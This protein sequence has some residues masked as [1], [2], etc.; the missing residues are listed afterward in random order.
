VSFSSEIEASARAGEPA[1]SAAVFYVRS[2]GISIPRNSA[3]VVYRAADFCENRGS[4]LRRKKVTLAGRSAR[5]RM[6]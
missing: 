3:A 2:A 4:R 5:R 1:A 6:K